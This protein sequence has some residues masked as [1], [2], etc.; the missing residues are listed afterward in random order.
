MDSE[1]SWLSIVATIFSLLSSAVTVIAYFYPE[2]DSL[3]ETL[4]E[5]LHSE[6]FVSLDE[7]VVHFAESWPY[8]PWLTAL[9]F[10]LVIAG[11]RFLAEVAFDLI[12][13]EVSFSGFLSQALLFMPL[14]LLWIWIFSGV[15]TGLGLLA[16]VVGYLISIYVSIFLASEFAP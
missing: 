11:L 14:A 13:I 7:A 1:R 15:V 4:G 9:L 2:G 16:F 12:T 10:F 5:L 8:G 6:F 3:L